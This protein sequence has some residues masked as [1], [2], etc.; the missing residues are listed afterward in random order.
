[1]WHN[2]SLRAV[3]GA[4]GPALH[5]GIGY[6][7]IMLGT[8]GVW[9]P[10]ADASLTDSGTRLRIGARFDFSGNDLPGTDRSLALELAGERSDTPGAAQSYRVTITLN[11]LY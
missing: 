6:G 3:G 4:A 1:M 9:T 11:V 2:D 5:A 10:F 8:G 7:I